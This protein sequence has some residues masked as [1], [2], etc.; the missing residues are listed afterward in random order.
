MGH[1]IRAALKNRSFRLC[2]SL[3]PL[4]KVLLG[5]TCS[6]ALQSSPATF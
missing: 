6:L 5:S 2:F 1:I 4:Y 3:F